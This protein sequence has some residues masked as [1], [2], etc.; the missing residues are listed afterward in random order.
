[1]RH[2]NQTR[3]S[4]VARTLQIDSSIQKLA[5]ALRESAATVRAQA[6]ADLEK[7]K[8]DEDLADHI[9][10]YRTIGG[11]AKLRQLAAGVVASVATRLTKTGKPDKRFKAHRGSRKM[12]ARRKKRF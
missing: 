6:E 4:T 2:A 12:K 11:P 3:S 1:M 5:R 9:E 7:A 10:T 8:L